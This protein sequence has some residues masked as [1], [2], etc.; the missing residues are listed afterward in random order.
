MVP[1]EEVFGQI[2]MGLR[3]ESSLAYCMAVGGRDEEGSECNAECTA[4]EP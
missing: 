3:S 1:P 2:L 4:E